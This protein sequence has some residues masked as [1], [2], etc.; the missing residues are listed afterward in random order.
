MRLRDGYPVA[1]FR[2]NSSSVSCTISAVSAVFFRMKGPAA[3]IEENTS[4]GAG[5]CVTMFK[6]ART[7]RM[8]AAPNPCCGRI[9]SVAETNSENVFARAVMTSR[10][11]LSAR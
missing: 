11:G 5:C 2:S 9:T 8:S 3:S 6:L 1:I 7:P 10:D 4:V